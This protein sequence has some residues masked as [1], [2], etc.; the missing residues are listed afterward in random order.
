MSDS[1]SRCMAFIE[2]VDRPD[3]VAPAEVVLAAITAAGI[4]NSDFFELDER[5]GQ[6]DGNYHRHTWH[7]ALRRVRNSDVGLFDRLAV[8]TR[9]T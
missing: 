9:P 1:Y 7:V 2:A 8:N 4:T 6:F 5:P 3:E